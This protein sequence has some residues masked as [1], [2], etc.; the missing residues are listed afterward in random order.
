MDHIVL[1]HD[2]TAPVAA[3]STSSK[4]LDAVLNGNGEAF[5]WGYVRY[6]DVFGRRRILRFGR[7]TKRQRLAESLA[8]VTNPRLYWSRHGDEA[9]NYD[10]PDDAPT[11]EL[12]D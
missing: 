1:E 3:F 10:G 12:A 5:L 2:E 4:G 11:G 9:Y 7:W 8:G 6:E